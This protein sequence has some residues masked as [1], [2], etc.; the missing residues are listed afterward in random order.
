MH[1]TPP[2]L[3]EQLRHPG[4]QDAWKRFAE[5]YTPLLYYW[6]RNQ[7]LSETDASDLVQEVFALLVVKLPHFHYEREGSFR[8]WLR[9]LTINKHRELHRRK[10]PHAVEHLED[11][12]A[13]NSD[14]ILE[15]K[16]Y[17]LHLVRQ[18]LHILQDQFP[19]S[20]WQLFREYV[21]ENRDPQAVAAENKV[22]LGTVYAAKSK[23]LYRLRQELAGLL[24]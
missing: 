9:T 21:I 5:L 7:H 20:T 10:R 8:G 4:Q 19:P 18:M 12:P 6:A 24:E 17:R 1:T 15:E 23:V 3:L 2:S 14:G 13:R 16:E 22:T 11:I